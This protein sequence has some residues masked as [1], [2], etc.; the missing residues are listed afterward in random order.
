VIE[1][2]LEDR[3]GEPWFVPIAV[4]GPSEDDWDQILYDNEK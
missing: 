3:F 1:E 2:K 4:V